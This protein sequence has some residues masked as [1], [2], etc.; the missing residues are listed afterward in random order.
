VYYFLLEHVVFEEI[1]FV[2]DEMLSSVVVRVLLLRVFRQPD[3]IFVFYF[4]LIVCI[5]DIFRVW[6]SY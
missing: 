1:C 3:G 2:F 5:L 4:F 6:T